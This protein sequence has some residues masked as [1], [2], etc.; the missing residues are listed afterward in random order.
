MVMDVWQASLMRAFA[1]QLQ[2]EQ[3]AEAGEEWQGGE[4]VSDGGSSE[5]E[6]WEEE[7]E[8]GEKQAR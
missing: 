4:A 7:E 2:R 3:Q 6:G 1:Q 8:E 5:E